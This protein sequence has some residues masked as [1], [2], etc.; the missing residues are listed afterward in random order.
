VC[1][2][3]DVGFTLQNG[4]CLASQS[5]CDRVNSTNGIC[6]QCRQGYALVGFKCVEV[7]RLAQYCLLYM[8]SGDC[9]TCKQGFTTSNGK[10]VLID[11][12]VKGTNVPVFAA[13]IQ[14]IPTTG[15]SQQPSATSPVPPTSQK[16]NPPTGIISSTPQTTTSSGSSS[17]QQ[18]LDFIMARLN[19]QCSAW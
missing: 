13:N 18:N 12:L 4:G 6:E 19:I 8:A 9:L 1:V 17:T 7:S 16:P 3:C 10:C 15:T 11:G 2:I 14:Q 5:N